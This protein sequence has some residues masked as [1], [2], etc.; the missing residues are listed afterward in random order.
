MRSATLAL[1]LL[2]SIAP[3]AAADDPQATYFSEGVLG[4]NDGER[5]LRPILLAAPDLTVTISW[6][7]HL[8]LSPAEEKNIEK[9]A[10]VVSGSIGLSAHLFEVTK[11]SFLLKA[12]RDLRTF[13]SADISP[14]QLAVIFA[15]V[16]RHGPE[17]KRILADVY[18]PLSKKHKN[19]KTEV[20]SMFR[21][22]LYFFRTQV[23]TISAILF[24]SPD[25]QLS[26]ASYCINFAIL[27]TSGFRGRVTS[28][29][30]Q[31]CKSVRCAARPLTYIVA[32]DIMALSAL[33]SIEDPLP[34]TALYRFKEIFNAAPPHFQSAR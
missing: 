19:L 21:C 32:W 10:L 4:A 1:A 30:E 2:I 24:V 9:I 17:M 31:S 14:N 18:Q 28:L 8:K 34:L 20:R 29:S 5:D 7:P 26:T 22:G 15:D 16:E 11:V 25:E 27:E 33:Y 6:M 23:N 12:D 13:T 3:I